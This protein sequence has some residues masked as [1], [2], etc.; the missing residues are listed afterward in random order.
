MWYYSSSG[1]SMRTAQEAHH[2]A[3]HIPAK[4]NV[5]VDHSST[6]VQNSP[7]ILIIR[8]TAIDFI[9]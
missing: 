2:L 8:K 3:Y 1:V 5:I 7:Y 9:F 4:D 6:T